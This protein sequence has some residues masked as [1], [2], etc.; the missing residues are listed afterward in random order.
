MFYHQDSDDKDWIYVVYVEGRGYMEATINLG[1][2]FNEPLISG[3]P[4]KELA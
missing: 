1:V 2:G 3:K 4:N